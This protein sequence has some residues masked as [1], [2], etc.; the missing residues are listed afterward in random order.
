MEEDDF[1][2]EV[3]TYFEP[4]YAQLREMGVTENRLPTAL[5]LLS[6]IIESVDKGL[7]ESWMRAYANTEG[8]VSK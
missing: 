2:S 3:D 7:M 8:Q 1:E 4:Y 5:H 6:H